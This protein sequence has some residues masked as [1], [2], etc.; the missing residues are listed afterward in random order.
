MGLCQVLGTM[1]APKF[2]ICR[3]E[4]CFSWDRPL[5][6]ECSTDKPKGTKI[7]LQTAS[8]YLGSSENT[9]GGWQPHL[10]QNTIPCLVLPCLWCPR[11]HACTLTHARTA[12]LYPPCTLTS[13][14]RH[15]LSAECAHIS[16]QINAQPHTH[17][18]TA[19]CLRDLHWESPTHPHLS[20]IVSLSAFKL[21]L[22]I[23]LLT[24]MESEF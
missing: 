4:F 12:P 15:M 17:N 13:P 23:Y 22:P 20:P 18:F 16:L 6:T 3:E 21:F 10:A 11:A 1:P 2:V 24:R 9:D 8:V 5:G 19:R 14:L 7:S